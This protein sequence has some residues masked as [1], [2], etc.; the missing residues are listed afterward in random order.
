MSSHVKWFVLGI[1]ITLVALAGGGY[2]F[3]KAG[4]VS[5]SAAAFRK[6]GHGDGRS[7]RR[8]ILEGDAWHPAVR[9]ARVWEHV[10]GHG[11]LAGNRAAG[12]RRQALAG[13]TSG[14]HPLSA[15]FQ[16]WRTHSFQPVKSP[17]HR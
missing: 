9:H 11:A 5:A 8:N 10:V 6:A 15:W 1:V 17:N 12:A 16:N 2:L 4:G 7:G 3:V 13:R 14:T